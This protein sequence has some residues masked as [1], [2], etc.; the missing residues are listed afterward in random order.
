VLDAP[1][2]LLHIEGDHI[3]VVAGDRLL[4]LTLDV[5]PPPPSP[6]LFF[7]FL[8]DLVL[9]QGQRSWF[10]PVSSSSSPCVARI[11][12]S[13]LVV[14]CVGPSVSVLSLAQGHVLASWAPHSEQE[15][16]FRPVAVAHDANGALFVLGAAQGALAVLT[17]APTPPS[18]ATK[19]GYGA[20]L[21]VFEG[22]AAPGSV[23]VSGALALA[24]TTTDD[25][26]LTLVD[27]PKLRVQSVPLGVRDPPAS[28]RVGLA[29]RLLWNLRSG[30]EGRLGRG[31]GRG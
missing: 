6:S 11:T 25:S 9:L 31:R 23:A 3:A 2:R 16:A 18:A 14:A 17:L 30:C 8:R 20:A 5:L 24:T 22:K 15:R 28:F 29:L 13:A 26:A 4:L 12:A 1:L 21:S 7:F 10:A 27:L 19:A